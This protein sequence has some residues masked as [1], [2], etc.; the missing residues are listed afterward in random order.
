MDRE[1]T[2]EKE[3]RKRSAWKI[4]ALTVLILLLILSVAL[5]ISRSSKNSDRGIIDTGELNAFYPVSADNVLGIYP[6]V[7]GVTVLTGNS[8]AY[9]DN[10]GNL[11]NTNIHSYASPVL[12]TAGKNLILYDKGSSDLRIEK[13]TVVYKTLKFDAEIGNADISPNGT[14]AYVLNSDGGYQ[15]HLFIYSYKGKKLFEWGG[16]DYVTDIALS[17]NGK[18]IALSL[19]SVNNA[20]YSGKVLCFELKKTEAVFSLDF[21]SEAV[22]DVEFISAKTVAFLSDSGTYTVNTKGE[23]EEREK[24]SANELNHTFISPNGLGVIALNLYGN[25]KN[26]QI[27]F[28]DKKFKNHYERNYAQAVTGVAANDL[29][30]ALVFPGYIDVFD[31]ANSQIGYVELTENCL[32]IALSGRR[33]YVLTPSG[34]YSYHISDV[35]YEKEE[36]NERD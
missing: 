11:M 19:L 16:S 36:F 20:E 21:P 2:T 35:R 10:S 17:K 5:V 24:Y 13:N 18:Y 15:S 7:D 30:T 6:Y 1:Q 14:Y 25:E 29:F 26:A 4:A 33:M 9:I 34:L 3:N 32:K 12:K 28:F 23:L 27:L 31:G 22:Y 8:V